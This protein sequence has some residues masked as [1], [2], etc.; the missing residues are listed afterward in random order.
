M[1]A[2]ICNRVFIL[3]EAGNPSQIQAAVDTYGLKVPKCPRV[4]SI[5]MFLL[6][7]SLE[8]LAW[9]KFVQRG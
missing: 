4:Y 6:Q 3:N 5:E 9:F 1:P 8:F 7:I 2:Q